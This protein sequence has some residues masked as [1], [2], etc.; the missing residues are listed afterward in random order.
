MG[1]PL[2]SDAVMAHQG[3]RHMGGRKNAS[4]GMFFFQIS[5]WADTGKHGRIHIT[6]KKSHIPFLHGQPC[7]QFYRHSGLSRSRASPYC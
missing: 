1:K 4:Q 2:M 6:Q 7:C 3:L 5:R